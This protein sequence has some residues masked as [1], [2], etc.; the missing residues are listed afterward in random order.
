MTITFTC[1]EAKE[2]VKETG[3]KIAD[4][5][6]GK[7]MSSLPLLISVITYLYYVP[8]TKEAIKETGSKASESAKETGSRIADKGR[9]KE[10]NIR[11]C[12]SQ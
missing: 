5:G 11:N 9:G 7:L 2:S 3:S 1:L 6:R 12:I 10:N 4:K 8:D